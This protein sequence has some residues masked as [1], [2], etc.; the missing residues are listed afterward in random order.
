MRLSLKVRPITWG[1]ELEKR[2]EEPDVVCKLTRSMKNRNKVGGVCHKGNG[3]DE[4]LLLKVGSMTS[5]CGSGGVWGAL[6]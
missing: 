4:I 5:G 3:L 1:R 6:G 2:R